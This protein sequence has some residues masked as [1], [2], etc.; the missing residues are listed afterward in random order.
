M[1][2]ISASQLQKTQMEAIWARKSDIPNDTSHFR[3]D[4]A[5]RPPEKATAEEG[6]SGTKKS[7]GKGVGEA[8]AE[9]RV[10]QHNHKRRAEDKTTKPAP[11]RNRL[12]HCPSRLDN[13]RSNGCR[14]CG[15]RRRGGSAILSRRRRWRRG[16]GRLWSAFLGL[17][18]GR[19][20]LAR[21]NR[22][23]LARRGLVS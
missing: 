7:A 13:R 21:C 3:A 19:V 4:S 22:A 14:R 2:A 20:G 5:G 6:N 18:W 8:G 9:Q 17:R 15:W 23:G 1:E 12:A 16:W 11:S 10:V